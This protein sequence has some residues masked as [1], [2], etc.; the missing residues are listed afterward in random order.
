M[1]CYKNKLDTDNEKINHKFPNPTLH[2][3]IAWYE[4]W[5]YVIVARYLIEILYL[6]YLKPIKGNEKYFLFILN[7]TANIKLQY[8]PMKECH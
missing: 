3:R 8:K 7:V 4:R 6:N 5:Y 1:P 2:D